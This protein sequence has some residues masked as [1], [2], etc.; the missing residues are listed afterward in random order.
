MN[1]RLKDLEHG[2]QQPRL[3]ME[4]D[5]PANTKTRKRTEGT[6]TAVQAMHGDSCFADQ[7]DP[8]PMCS[9]SFGDDCTGPP[10]LPC[11][12][13]TALVDNSAAAP[14]SCFT[15]GDGHNNNRRWLTLRRHD[16]YSDEDTFHQLPFWFC[17]TKE[18]NLRASVL[19]YTSRT[20]AAL[21]GQKTSKPSSGRESLKQNRGKLWCLIQ[22][23]R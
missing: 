1:Q 19:L 21:G 18:T 6:A 14:K 15:L 3:S 20:S 7:V 17:L 10:A 22:E 4:T 2:A 9:T 16:H 12:G 8:D 23:G 11:S 13:E 5:G